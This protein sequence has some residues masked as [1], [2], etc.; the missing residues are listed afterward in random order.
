MSA[1]SMAR[2][3]MNSRQL[4]QLRAGINAGDLSLPP[5]LQKKFKCCRWTR[6]ENRVVDQQKT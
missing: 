3:Q 6:H 4:V 5:D 1:A 2:R